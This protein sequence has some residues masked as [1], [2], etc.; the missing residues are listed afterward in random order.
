MS[1]RSSAAVES[2]TRGSSIFS[3]GGIA[4]SEPVASS[5]CSNCTASSPPAVSFT[6]R[7]CAS[8][9]SA[10]P[11]MY[12]TL[13]CLTSCPVPLVSRLTTLSLKPRS[14]IEVDR[15]LAELDAPRLGVARF[16]DQLGDV[17]QRLGRNAAAIDADAAGVHFRID[18]RD[19]EPE[20]RGKKSGGV[21]AGP[22]PTTTSWTEII[23]SLVRCRSRRQVGQIG[24]CSKSTHRSSGPCPQPSRPSHGLSPAARAGRVSPTPGR[25]SAGSGCRRRRRSRGDRRTA[26]AAA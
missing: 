17:K 7:L 12:C 4:G 8:T 20:I 13:R 25:P 9:I 10:R 21:P 26:T 18:Q 5:A 14:L 15:R 22:A 1:G 19:A 3:A 2:I 23:V 11:W 16:V 6:V 24:L